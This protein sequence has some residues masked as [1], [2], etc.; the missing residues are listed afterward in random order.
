MLTPFA[1]L[2]A[3]RRQG[4]AVGAFT[5]YDLETAG[6]ALRAA[7]GAGA[8][9]ILLI[10]GRS[11]RERDGDLLLAALIAVAARADARACVQLDHCG[12]LEVMASALEAGAGAL[13]ADG[14][15][16]PFER[17]VELVAAAARLARSRG[18]SVE[19]ELGGIAGD[20]DVA[21][22]VAAGALT[23]PAQAADFVART[24]A[25]CLAVSIGNVH[26]SYR[27]KPRLD[28]DRLEAI[29]AAIGTPLSLH[30]ASGIPDA[31][32]R[33]SIA[34]GIAKINVNTELRGAYLEATGE[35]LPSL[36]EGSRLNVL[37]TAQSDAVERVIA[38]K[39]R[40]FDTGEPG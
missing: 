33:R 21:E 17:N 28:W 23:D 15:A 20:E 34:T 38:A 14:S 4:S 10:G 9:V 31:M 30:G 16:L 32:L 25:D 27:E 24:G 37:H 29:R 3:H 18:A 12:D 11:Y 35:I 13:L 22:A 40:A 26:G 7:A 2:L 19:A 1:D 39:L 8:G 6:A 36:L 5:C